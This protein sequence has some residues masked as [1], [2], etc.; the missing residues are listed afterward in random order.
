MRERLGLAMERYDAGNTTSELNVAA[1]WV[2][3]VRELFDLMPA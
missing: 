3:D 2:Q 1:G